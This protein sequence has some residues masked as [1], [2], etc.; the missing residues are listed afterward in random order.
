MVNKPRSGT[1]FILIESKDDCIVIF[2][3]SLLHVYSFLFNNLL[4][5]AI[6]H[7]SCAV[8]CVSGAKTGPVTGGGS[9]INPGFENG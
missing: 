5:L 4:N 1:V 9:S 2:T 7:V 3:L 6:K 8:L